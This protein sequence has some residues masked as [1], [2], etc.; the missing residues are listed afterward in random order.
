M[1]STHANGTIKRLRDKVPVAV[2]DAVLSIPADTLEDNLTLEM[3]P[4]EVVHVFAP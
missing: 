2:A 1:G 3:A 4:F